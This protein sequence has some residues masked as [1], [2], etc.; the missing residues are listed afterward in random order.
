MKYY[1]GLVFA[2]LIACLI[3]IFCQLFS[4]KDLWYESYAAIIGVVLTAIITFFLF[5][6]QTSS[7]VKREKEAKV[8]EEKLKIYKEFLNYL[9]DIIQDRKITEEEKV[10]LKFRPVQIFFFH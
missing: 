4:I 5:K 8:Y 10:K 3:P 7:E 1:I 2:C 6:G 9:C